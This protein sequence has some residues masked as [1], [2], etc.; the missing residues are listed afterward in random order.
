MDNHFFILIITMQLIVTI[1][2]IGKLSDSKVFDLVQT[3][4]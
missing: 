1:Q 4:E 2:S 3:S